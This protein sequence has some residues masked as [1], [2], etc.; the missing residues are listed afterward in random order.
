MA[1]PHFRGSFVSAG[2]SPLSAAAYNH[3]TTM[4]DRYNDQRFSYKADDDL[5]HA[6]IAI[7]E[8][9]PDWLVAL[10][11]DKL[12]AEQSSE[13]W[14]KVLQS[15]RQDV[16]QTARKFIVALPLELDRERNIALVRDYVASELTSRGWVVDWVYHDK[17]GNPHVHIMHT[18]RPL[19]ECGFGPKRIAVLDETGAV[20]R[21]AD[22]KIVY[23]QFIGNTATLVD[24]RTAWAQAATRHLANAGHDVVLDLGSYRDRGITLTPTTHIGPTGKTFARCDLESLS[25]DAHHNQKAISILDIERDPS[26]IIKLVAS[27]KS[28]FDERDLARA[29]HTFIDDEVVFT[30]ALSRALAHPDLVRLAPATVDALGHRLDPERLATRP[31][32]ALE[33]GLSREALTLAASRNGGL[34]EGVVRAA[35]ADATLVLSEEQV[36]AVLHVTIGTDLASVVGYAGAGKSTLLGVAHAAWRASGRDVVGAALAG[37]AASGLA[38]SSSIP[39]RTIASWRY[40]W[41]QGRDHLSAN[42]VFVVDEAGMVGSADMAA[43]VAEVARAGAK[44]VLV[45]DPEQLQPIAAG[46]AFRV[47]VEQSRALV[48]SDVRRQYEPWARAATIAFER[49]QV[50]DAVAAYA[51]HDAVQF[52]PDRLAAATALVEAYMADLD[53]PARNGGAATQIVLA[54]RNDDILTLN[55]AIQERRAAAGQLGPLVGVETVKG[56]R[57]IGVGDRLLFLKKGEFSTDTGDRHRVSNNDLGTIASVSVVGKT[58]LVSVVTD[59][60]PKIAFEAGANPDFDL[61]YA[62]TIHKSQGATEERSYVLASASM[63]KPL[64]LVALSRHR[65]TTTLFVPTSEIADLKDLSWNFARSTPKETTTDYAERRGITLDPARALQPKITVHLAPL[66]AS[67]RA[68]VATAH[69]TLNAAWQRCVA[70]MQALQSERLDR[71]KILEPFEILPAPSVAERERAVALGAMSIKICDDLKAN[72]NLAFSDHDL[73]V[74]DSDIGLRLPPIPEAVAALRSLRDAG[75]AV[76]YVPKTDTVSDGHYWRVKLHDAADG[77]AILAAMT[78]ATTI[79]HSQPPN[80]TIAADVRSPHAEIILTARGGK[81]LAQIPNMPE[82]SDYLRGPN[83]NPSAFVWDRQEKAYAVLVTDANVDGVLRRLGR[84]AD[85]YVNRAYFSPN[86]GKPGLSFPNDLVLTA[87]AETYVSNRAVA[88]QVDRFVERVQA[89]LSLAAVEE[90]N[91][92]SEGSK[93]NAVALTMIEPSRLDELSRHFRSC[94]TI[95]ANGK[96]LQHAQEIEKAKAA[97]H[98]HGPD[99]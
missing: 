34:S 93:P 79:A 82:V 99:I 75:I 67:A 20:R 80:K 88:F 54:H 77:A 26:C 72:K 4:V 47:L 17:P 66:V 60:G 85:C 6:E 22:N 41:G 59:G 25:I 7:P 84:V 9:S 10:A 94:Q 44:L 97:S 96:A 5:V 56:P 65:E 71:V 24:L 29:L 19:T 30:R 70:A 3:R 11:E 43:I 78:A 39:S 32:I 15:E 8:R 48:L 31:M 50:A 49:G 18:L 40:A 55:T 42:S 27:Q 73:F 86:N 62:T 92:R 38:A 2:Q 57:Q 90:L 68:L 36:A 51:A 91:T 16:A 14:N 98:D 76:S 1:I 74:R 87:T 61:G 95:A 45:G 21:S 53:K 83:G 69:A 33:A 89:M 63:D 81:L 58:V 13:L 52:A 12:P 37:K 46:G 23:R 28:V 35:I 64:A